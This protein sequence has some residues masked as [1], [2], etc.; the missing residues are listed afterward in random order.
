MAHLQENWTNWHRARRRGAA[1]C[2]RRTLCSN[3]HP[4][5]CTAGSSSSTKTWM[6]RMYMYYMQAWTR[7]WRQGLLGN[8]SL[9]A[10]VMDELVRILVGRL[11]L[12][13]PRS[14]SCLSIHNNTDL[15]CI[16]ACGDY[17]MHNA[18]AT[19][20]VLQR[21]CWNNTIKVTEYLKWF[22]RLWSLVTFGKTMWWR[23]SQHRGLLTSFQSF[24]TNL[25]G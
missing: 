15:N 16:C 9:S 4:S 13:L 2:S 14:S 11:F 7:A 3:S 8:E 6:Y 21:L 24:Q 18:G 12:S 1:W 20:A 25:T 5:Y 17:S 19:T 10:T 22:N 23:A